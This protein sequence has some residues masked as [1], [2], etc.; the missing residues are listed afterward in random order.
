[1]PG[2]ILILA[3]DPEVALFHDARGL[4]PARYRRTSVPTTVRIAATFL[5]R[6]AEDIPVAFM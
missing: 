6:L 1:M 4:T 2:L 5:A 3:D